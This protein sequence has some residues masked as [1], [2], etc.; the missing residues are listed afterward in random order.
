MVSSNE[1]QTSGTN[2]LV[3]LLKEGTD[4]AGIIHHFELFTND[5][6]RDMVI[7]DPECLIGDYKQ[8]ISMNGFSTSIED[9]LFYYEKARDEVLKTFENDEELLNAHLTA[10][11]SAFKNAMRDVAF[12]T[13]MKLWAQNCMA[14]QY[15][16]EGVKFEANKLAVNKDFKTAE[17][18]VNAQKVLKEFGQKFIDSI[19]NGLNYDEAK[20]STFNYMAENFKTTSVNSLSLSDLI[21]VGKNMCGSDRVEGKAANIAQWSEINRK[22]NESK[23]LSA[24]LRALLG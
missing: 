13:S 20:K 12:Y 17:F 5:E 16:N 10:I 18:A 6:Y 8:Y 14:R 19:K 23:E 24:E 4:I 22:F 21:A 7:D 2:A 1:K 11:D 15:E 9:K 3:N